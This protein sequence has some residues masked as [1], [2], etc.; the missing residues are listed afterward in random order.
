[1]FYSFEFSAA[2][3]PNP[4]DLYDRIARMQELAPLWVDVTWGFGNVGQR[5][6]E[7]CRHIQKNLGLP[8]LMHFICTDM[9]T[10]DLEANLDAA[11]AA[12]VRAILALR[13]Y[14]QAGFA[15][16]QPCAHGDGA[17]PRHAADLVRLI[18]RRHGDHFS[19]GVAGFPE[20]HPE[21]G[22][23]L[24]ADVEH[25]KAKLNAGAGFVI[26]QFGFDPGAFRR[27]VAR[28]RAAGIRAP[29]LP[30]VM[31]LTDHATGRLLSDAWGVRL[32]RGLEARLRAAADPEAARRAGSAFTAALCARLLEEGRAAGEG[33]G[34][35]LFVY[36]AER[37]IREL[38]GRLRR[39]GWSV[40]GARGAA[41]VDEGPRASE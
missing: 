3:D 36:D 41:A 19:I 16:W 35:H 12:G 4:K 32:P 24:D 26:C 25:L 40:Q 5:S 21:S 9:T 28:C 2:R 15:E 14:T 22:G 18:R 39:G 7:A 37:D 13:G 38:L 34:L 31:P 17:E 1:M 33:C 11:R 23:D 6:I 10:A 29:I 27:F 20:G 30:G 8:V